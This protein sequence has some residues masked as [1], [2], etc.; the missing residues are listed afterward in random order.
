MVRLQPWS[1]QLPFLRCQE[2]AKHVSEKPAALVE[3]LKKRSGTQRETYLFTLWT[4]LISNTPRAR[5]SAHL[6][7]KSGG[8]TD[9]FGRGV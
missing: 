7:A 8:R 9:E 4:A 3:S 5:P 6:S 1:V 2:G